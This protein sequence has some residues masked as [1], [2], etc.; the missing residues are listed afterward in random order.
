MVGFYKKRNKYIKLWTNTVNCMNETL[1]SHMAP[2]DK[3]R[4]IKEKQII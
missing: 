3:P 4:S 1:T 2:F